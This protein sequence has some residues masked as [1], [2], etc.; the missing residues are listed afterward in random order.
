MMDEKPKGKP[1]PA[2]EQ[3]PC[4]ICGDSR[5]TWGK[6]VDD[7]PSGGIYFR[8]KAGIWGDGQ[9]LIARRCDTCQNVQFFIE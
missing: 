1:R 8:P 9:K 6:P 4:P 5:Y 2:I 3:G 7:T